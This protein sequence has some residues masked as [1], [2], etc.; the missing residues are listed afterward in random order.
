MF[1][2]SCQTNYLNISY[3]TDLRQIFGVGKI[4]AVEDHSEI[5]FSI[6]QGTLP[7]QPIFVVGFIHT[8]EFRW[9]SLDCISVRQ[10]SSGRVSLDAGGQWL[11]RVG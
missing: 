5:C 4:T 9:H 2:D 8:T 10:N 7:R 3:G 11:S 6:P 1:D